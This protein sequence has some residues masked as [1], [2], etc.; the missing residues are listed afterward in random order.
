[1]TISLDP[2]PFSPTSLNLGFVLPT[3]VSSPR[4]QKKGVLG[5]TAEPHDFHDLQKKS[6][7]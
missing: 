4:T 5:K 2:K 7:I 1:M 3:A 6:F